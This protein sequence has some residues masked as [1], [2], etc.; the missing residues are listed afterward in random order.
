MKILKAL[1]PLATLTAFCYFRELMKSLTKENIEVFA[2]EQ[3][4]S[5]GDKII[6]R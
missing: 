4:Q 5:L 6:G 3:L 2:I 1:K